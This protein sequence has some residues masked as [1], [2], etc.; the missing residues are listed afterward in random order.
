[1]NRRIR[2]RMHARSSLVLCASSLFVHSTTLHTA[3]PQSQNTHTTLFA[4]FN[5]LPP[6]HTRNV[7]SLPACVQLG[8]LLFGLFH[9]RPSLFLDPFSS[10]HVPSCTSRHTNPSTFWVPWRFANPQNESVWQVALFSPH[11]RPSGVIALTTTPC[12]CAGF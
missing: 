12:V 11:T 6:P 1:M 7:L 2:L 4:H 5:G 3:M 8:P 9:Y 10:P